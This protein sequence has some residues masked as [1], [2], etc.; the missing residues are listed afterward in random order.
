MVFLYHR[1]YRPHFLDHESIPRFIRN[2]F[3]KINSKFNRKPTELKEP[4]Y[5][6][7]LTSYPGPILKNKLNDLELMSPDFVYTQNF[8]NYQK[9]IGNYFV[10]CDGNTFLDLYTNNGSLPLGYNEG[11]LFNLT[12]ENNFLRNF[13]NKIGIN[14]YMTEEALNNLEYITDII[15]PKKVEKLIMTKSAGNSAN[16]LAVKL[17]MQRRFSKKENQDLKQMSLSDIRKSSNFSVMSFSNLGRNTDPLNV[18][19]SNAEHALGFESFNWPVAPFPDIKYPLKE[20]EKE[21][22]EEEAKCLED[23]ERLLK[24]NSNLCA[25][26]VEPILG[27]AGDFW[28]SP[29]YFK[30]LRKLATQY[31]VDFIVDEVNTGMSTG[32]YWLHELWDL[33]KEPDMVTFGKKFQ[34]SGVFLRK[35]FYGSKGAPEEM[36]RDSFGE[37]YRLDNLKRLVEIV[38]K[39]NLF[40]KAEKTADQFKDDL[41]SLNK[42][43]NFPLSNIRG[44]GN[45]LAFDL[46]D[47]KKRD[48]F[49]RFIRNYGI[50]VIGSGKNTVRLRPTLTL[51]SEH[52]KYLINS[53]EDY[54][55]Q[56]I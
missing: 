53:T 17:S 6:K 14:N 22:L 42:T 30:N 16:E 13:N 10:D 51:K 47:G 33:D 39:N 9:S 32:R 19:R 56:K 11:N 7:M 4:N 8:I 24:L 1:L 54:L 25:M 27:E 34:N 43:Y 26:F 21:N 37:M 48:S 41:R 46:E 15:A 2:L 12:K 35:E 52:F 31:N 50:F 49:V 3:Y 36:C 40:M 5:P 38:E 28:A 45:M 29:N 55:Q 18:M 44:K 23:T 20:N